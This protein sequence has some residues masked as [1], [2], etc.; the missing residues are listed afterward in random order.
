MNRGLNKVLLIGH[1]GSDPEIMSLSNGGVIANLNIGTSES[2]QDKQT[3]QP[4]ERTEWHRVVFF[5]RLAEIVQQYVRKGANLWIEA[6]LQTRQYE[7]NGKTKYTTD[8]VAKQ[9]QMLNSRKTQRP[10]QQ[11]HQQYGG[12]QQPTYQPKQATHTPKTPPQ[13]S[14]QGRH[15]GFDNDFDDDIP[16]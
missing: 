15:G 7:K 9:M 11:P 2:W 5:N 16:F 6:S 1:V 13:Q 12:M 8:I 3:G 4:Q 14:N 10:V